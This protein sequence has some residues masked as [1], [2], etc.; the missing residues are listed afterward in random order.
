M[1]CFLKFHPCATTAVWLTAN[2]L[3][4][5]LRHTRS[6]APRLGRR[7][8]TLGYIQG[9][10]KKPCC[11]SRRERK[12][13]REER[14]PLDQY[15]TLPAAPPPPGTSLSTPSSPRISLISLALLFSNQPAN[16]PP[17]PSPHPTLSS[18]LLLDVLALA[19]RFNPWKRE[20]TKKETSLL[21]NAR[22]R[23]FR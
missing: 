5:K 18:S 2:T 1:R 6:N 13:V 4:G 8:Q 23:E 20:R 14:V 15:A 21:S 11:Y 19:V 9:G 7:T 16:P 3:R 17:P 22:E 12:R 10:S